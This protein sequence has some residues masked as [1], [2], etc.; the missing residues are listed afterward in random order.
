MDELENSKIGFFE[1]TSEYSRVECS[2]ERRPFHS[3]PP[4]YRTKNRKPRD[5]MIEFFV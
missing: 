2:V 3:G 1:Q 4:D 5:F